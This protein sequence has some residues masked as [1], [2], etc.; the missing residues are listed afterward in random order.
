[1]MKFSQLTLKLMVGVVVLTGSLYAEEETQQIV[2]KQIEAGKRA[3]TP[4]QLTQLQEKRLLEASEG[5][6]EED[7]STAQPTEEMLAISK[8]LRENDLK[9]MAKSFPKDILSKTTYTTSH[10]G[11]LHYPASVSYFGATVTLGDGSMWNIYSGDRYLTLNWYISDLVLILP[12][13]NLFSIYNYCLV[14][15]QTGVSVQANLAVGPYYNGMNT[16]WIVAFDDYNNQVCLNDGSIWSVSSLDSYCLKSWYSNDTLIMG[17]NDD[18]YSS[19]RP[20]ILINVNT[21]NHVRANCIYY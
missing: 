6:V 3:S 9:P 13:H 17:F 16:Y 12:N 7:T 2:Q 21:L 10:P 11:A 8:T 15:Q 18:F 20:N 5:S 19:I 14:N 4:A 1:M